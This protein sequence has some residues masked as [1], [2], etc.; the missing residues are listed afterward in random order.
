[1]QQ[2]SKSYDV[3]RVNKFNLRILYGIAIILIYG[4]GTTGGCLF[5]TPTPS[6][7]Y[8][9]NINFNFWGVYS[10]RVATVTS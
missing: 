2:L 1:M 6:L 4:R 3:S 9:H 7:L 8:I 5:G 10:Y